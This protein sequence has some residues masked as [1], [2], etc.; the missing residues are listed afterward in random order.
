[1]AR[2]QLCRV[3][4]WRW[5]RNPLR[6][7]SDLVEAWLVLAAWVI[8]LLG[9]ALAGVAAASTVGRDL[10]QQRAER[11]P[12]AAV[13]TQ[14]APAGPSA[15]TLDGGHVWAPVRWQS[16]D[17]STHLA[18]TEVPPG[19]PQGTRVTVWTDAHGKLTSK[20]LSGG[21]ATFQSAWT[22]VLVAVATAGGVA[23]CAQFARS[24]LEHRRMEQWAKEW[25][26]VDTRWGGKTG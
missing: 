5:R 2:T 26:R 21:D 11:H 6:R 12:V 15:Q 17:G 19:A 24:R 14:D 10:A 9:S 4:A 22:G 23:G 16:P 8:A 1:M 13:V 7:R 18:R 20:P 3:R 25:E